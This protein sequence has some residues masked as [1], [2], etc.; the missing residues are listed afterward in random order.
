MN[1]LAA[2]IFSPKVSRLFA[3]FALLGG[4]ASL[5]A[6][7]E[8]EGL[9]LALERARAEG[10]AERLGALSNELGGLLRN[11][12]EDE[13]AEALFRAAA[14]QGAPVTALR[15]SINLAGPM[16]ERGD[17]A[18]FAQGFDALLARA[19]RLEAGR[20]RAEIMAALGRLAQ[21]APEELARTLQER[22]EALREAIAACSPGNA[23]TP[24]A[25][26]ILENPADG[27]A[28]LSPL[29]ALARAPELRACLDRSL[30][31]AGGQG[32]ANPLA[33]T[34]FRARLY[35]WDAL[36]ALAAGEGEPALRWRAA[37]YRAL[38][39]A[40]ETAG[41]GGQA[42]TESYA[43]GY[44]GQ[45]YEQEARW[46]EAL[47]LT[48]RAAFLAQSAGGL[49]SLYLWHWQTGRLLRRQQ[50]WQGA[51]AAY[52]RAAQTIQ[53]LRRD[54]PKSYDEREARLYRNGS[55][56]FLELIDLLLARASLDGEAAQAYL[57][58]ARAMLELSKTSE[59]ED[60]FQD[61]CDIAAKS[62]MARLDRAIP[63]A[64][65][66]YP[67][68]F[69]DRAEIL[70]SLPDGMRRYAVPLR[71]RGI[72]ARVK[73]LRT[74]L[75]K[76]REDYLGVAREL[77]DLLLRPMM[78]AIDAA[79]VDALVIVPDGALRMIPWS[80]LHD[81]RGFLIERYAVAITPGLTL[82]DLH[83]TARAGEPVTLLANGL[84]EAVQGF[85]A[86][87]SVSRE[88]QAIEAE[89]GGKTLLNENFVFDKLRK[90]LKKEPYSIVHIASHG[91]FDRKSNNSFVLTFD[92]RLSVN[93]LENL[94]GLSKYRDEPVDLL[95]L[96][97][98][99]TAAGD[100]RAA[101]GLGGIA[102][103]AGARSALATLWQIGDESTALLMRRF[104]SMLVERPDIPK[105]EALRQAQ[106]KLLK[107]EPRYAHPFFWSPFLLIGNW[108]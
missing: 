48:R 84:S 21:R 103:K 28:A 88:I 81:G 76:R 96:S 42:L 77:Y 34:Q 71:K 29:L 57:M 52:R 31:L 51:L 20:D 74:A 97:A 46:G 61:A 19:D 39:D 83:E 13:E 10:G 95:V 15:A 101:L 75:E 93:Q 78:P 62:K 94:L 11:R 41:R 91:H 24:G 54:L 18:A 8:E 38:R 12:G 63:H 30:T 67:I 40:A 82:T 90:A 17:Y 27:A 105:P 59:L 70:L 43:L 25:R 99:Q 5:A 100:D 92:G 102:I 85:P 68:L 32:G 14:E 35:A 49:E 107:E 64:A 3:A 1:A 6:G 16:L 22:F 80:V 44:M 45:L 66:A 69:D 72:E 36:K 89:S 53:D 87:P 56:V 79:R 47:V 60:Y 106:L 7:S 4:L 104:Y 33:R 73:T 98:C 86:L 108:H 50:D 65:I 23:A 9:R 37:A 2:T 26:A 58:E 55:A